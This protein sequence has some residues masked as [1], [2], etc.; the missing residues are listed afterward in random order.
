MSLF[1]CES[2]GAVENTALSL[3]GG[4]GYAEKFFDWTGY[5]DKKGKRLCSACLPD[6]NSAGE[7]HEYGKWHGEF[8]KTILPLGQFRT[9]EQGN[10]E[11]IET[12]DTDFAKYAL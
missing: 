3:Q 10:L 1:Q 8:S 2:C 5:E 12:G 7:P 9:N 4:N 11:H 6:K